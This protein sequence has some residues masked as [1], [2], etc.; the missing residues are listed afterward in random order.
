MNYQLRPSEGS[1]ENVANA[2]LPDN[3]A[4]QAW[5]L[6]WVRHNAAHSSYM[7]E[8]TDGGF[9]MAVFRTNYGQWYVMPVAAGAEGGV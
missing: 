4:A 7:L 6:E 5:A 9:S 1:S 2:D 8:S 3:F